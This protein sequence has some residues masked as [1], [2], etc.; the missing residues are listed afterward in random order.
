MW[1]IASHIYFEFLACN[2]SHVC[3]KCLQVI[4]YFIFCM[5]LFICANDC[6]PYLFWICG[7]QLFTR[8]NN[9]TSCH[10]LFSCVKSFICDVRMVASHIYFELVDCNH[11]YVWTIA[12]HLIF[13]FWTAIVCTYKQLQAMFFFFNCGVQSFVHANDCKSSHI[14]SFEF[15]DCNCSHVR[16]I[17][18]RVFYLFMEC[19]HSYVVTQWNGFHRMSIN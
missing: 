14:L 1:T 6:K 11:L 9:C 13:C 15:M 10:V 8:T 12:S 4:S 17:A 2:H 7:L 5:K 19:N 3:I 18:S 16:M